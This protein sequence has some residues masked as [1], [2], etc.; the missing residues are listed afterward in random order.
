MH[1]ES[2]NHKEADTLLI[3]HAVQELRRNPKEAKLMLFTPDTDFLVLVIANYE[4]LPSDT[5]VSM[6]SGTVEVEP[7][8]T[9]LGADHA[10]AFPAFHAF[11]EADNTGRCARLAK[12]SW[13]NLYLQADN[14]VL[15]AFQTLMQRNEVTEDQPCALATFVCAAYSPKGVK[16][17]NIPELRWH[18]F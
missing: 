15:Q 8:W 13:F 9:A 6:V 16:I 12:V 17:D 1:F 7:I 10:K 5:S 18:L 3:H 11:T 4:N 14:Q 2:N